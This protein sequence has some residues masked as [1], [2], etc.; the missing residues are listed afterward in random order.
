MLIVED[1]MIVA[2]DVETMLGEHGCD[3]LN[4]AS[5]VQEA[6]ARIS[7]THPDVVILD[8]NLNGTRT[9]EVALALNQSGIPYV[10]LTGYSSGVS[11]EPAMASAPCIAK[12]W[13]AG[14]LLR[15]LNGLVSAAH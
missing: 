7:Q 3:V 11:D 1:E 5:T 15:E 6:L 4:T 10:V 2:M 9:T 8:R 13:N 14:E 12:P